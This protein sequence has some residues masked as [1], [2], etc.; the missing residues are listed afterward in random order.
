MDILAAIKRQERKLEKQSG[1]LQREL[2]GV[3]AAAKVLGD[4]AQRK[5]IGVKRRVLSAAGRAAIIKTAKMRRAKVRKQ[6]KRVARRR[7][8][9]P[10]KTMIQVVHR[11]SALG[12]CLCN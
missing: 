6:A 8:L 3:G 11:L 1:K 2:N 5:A 10:Q 4:S 12:E 9:S 7:I